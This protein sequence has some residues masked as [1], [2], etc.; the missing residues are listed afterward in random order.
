MT[1]SSIR[2]AEAKIIEG[3]EGSDKI[4]SQFMSK[5]NKHKNNCLYQLYNTKH[6]VP[7]SKNI[8]SMTKIIEMKHFVSMI[9]V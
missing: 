9:N 8:F 6:H 7:H 5:I 2:N 4:L 1:R 3:E